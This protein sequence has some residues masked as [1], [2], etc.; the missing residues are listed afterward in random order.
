MSQNK[1]KYTNIFRKAR[2]NK[3]TKRKNQNFNKE[4]Y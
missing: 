4:E 1:N 3:K 2:K